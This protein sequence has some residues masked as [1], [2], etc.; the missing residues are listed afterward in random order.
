MLYLNK[1]QT[2]TLTIPRLNDLGNEAGDVYLFVFKHEQQNVNLEIELTDVSLFP[3]RYSEFE[4][5]LPADLEDMTFDG[6]YS[7]KIYEDGLLIW[8]G[9]AI[10]NPTMYG[11]ETNEIELGNNKIYEGDRT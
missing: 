7:V 1:N 5:T 3:Y 6:E 11:A 8:K 2:N 4:F 10:L 9:K